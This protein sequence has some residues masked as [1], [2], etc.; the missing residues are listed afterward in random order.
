MNI[1]FLCLIYCTYNIHKRHKV[2]IFYRNLFRFEFHQNLTLRHEFILAISREV[3]CVESQIDR[4]TYIDGMGLIKRN[5]T[6]GGWEARWNIHC[7][8]GANVYITKDSEPY[9]PLVYP[10]GAWR[11]VNSEGSGV[12]IRVQRQREVGCLFW[13]IE[14]SE[15]LVKGQGHTGVK[16]PFPWILGNIQAFNQFHDLATVRVDFPISLQSIN[17]MMMP[18]ITPKTDLSIFLET[19]S[20]VR[21]TSK[22]NCHICF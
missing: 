1:C 20:S 3:V 12:S 6:Q 14:E 11:C 5:G 17:Y 15:C 7:K 22:M 13:R 2:I 8:V 19:L 18:I 21:L 4:L 16:L 9:E 10:P